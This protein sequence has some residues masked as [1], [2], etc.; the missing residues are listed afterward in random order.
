[1]HAGLP[2]AARVA[3]ASG[4]AG[5]PESDSRPWQPSGGKYVIGDARTGVGN[6]AVVWEGPFEEQVLLLG[7]E[8]SYL[9]LPGHKSPI[10]LKFDAVTDIM[11]FH[12]TLANKKLQLKT[13]YDGDRAMGEMGF[14]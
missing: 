9:E 3:V 4:H 14:G 5:V 7:R 12:H 10:T 8:H 11:S 13:K 6:H 1:M 2:D